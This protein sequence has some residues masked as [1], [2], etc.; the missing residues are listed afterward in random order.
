MILQGELA[1]PL[2]VARFQ[3][4]AQAAAGL[5]HPHIVPIYE[6]GEY[7]GQQYYA[8][9]FVEGTSLA[10]QPRGDLRAGAGLLAVVARAVHYAHQR[11]ILHRD[12]KPANILIDLERWLRGEPIQ[13]RPVGS[14]GRFARWCRRN[15]AVAGSAG[16]TNRGAITS[17]MIRRW[18]TAR[19]LTTTL[20]TSF[21]VRA[22]A[23][24]TLVICAGA[25]SGLAAQR[26][27][28]ISAPVPSVKQILIKM[29]WSPL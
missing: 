25:S 9:R 4:E 15:P 6:V 2:D 27:A 1:T 21:P 5:D 11:G 24:T 29:F 12:L 10:R 16:D 18:F 3:L 14:L 22:S 8:M 17:G 13:A 28:A 19:A 20:C 26:L 7:E 23:R